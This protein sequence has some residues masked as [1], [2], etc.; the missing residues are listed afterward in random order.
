MTKIAHRTASIEQRTIKAQRIPELMAS[1]IRRRILRGELKENDSLPAEAELRAQYD[2]SRPT[3]REA[4]RILESEQLIVIRRGG[5]GGAL[6]R[7]PDLDAAARQ[8]GFVLQDQGATMGDLHRARALI[9]PPALAALAVTCRPEQ[10]SELHEML[11]VCNNYVGDVN[12]FSRATEQLRERII[13]MTGA[14]TIF[15]VMRMLRELLQKHTAS[16]GATP[17]DRWAKLQRLSQRSHQRLLDL[18][19][20]GDPVAAEDFWRDHLRQVEHHLGRPATM[21]VI[22]MLE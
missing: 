22:D 16:V 5:I 18:I 1:D 3:L 19:G 11:A 4:M 7:K 9:E 8:F 14:I 13:A 15:M 2:V 12:A 6:I 10:L 21:R 17:A 20:S